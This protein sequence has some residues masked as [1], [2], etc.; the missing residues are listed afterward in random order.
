MRR[1]IPLV[2]G[3]LSINTN[4]FYPPAPPEEIMHCPVLIWLI[5]WDTRLILFDTGGTA[6]EVAYRTGHAHYQRSAAEA[7]Q[8]K[9]REQLG[10]DPADVDLVILSHLHWD[11]AANWSMFPR[12]TILVQSEEV[13][14]ALAPEPSHQKYFDY[15][16][17]PAGYIVADRFTQVQGTMPLADAAGLQLIPLPGHTPGSQGLLLDD[18]TR[19]FILAGDAVPLYRNW[20]TIP[21][22]PNG[23]AC[24]M[25]QFRQTLTNLEGWKAIVFPSHEPALA[26]FDGKDILNGGGI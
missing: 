20:Q 15:H 4:T 10:I 5:E 3:W 16:A 22:V 24:N 23:I 12:A 2:V 21:P 17:H 11:H 14:F 25:Q 8:T 6:P 9:L 19:R 26:R 18:G 1:L 7:P 13:R